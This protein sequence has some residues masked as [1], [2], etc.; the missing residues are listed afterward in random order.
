MLMNFVFFKSLQTYYDETAYFLKNITT[1][2]NFFI[3]TPIKL[4][5]VPSLSPP[6]SLPNI[7]TLICVYTDLI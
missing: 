4:P 3:K 2:G 7:I 6:L 1:E 5:H